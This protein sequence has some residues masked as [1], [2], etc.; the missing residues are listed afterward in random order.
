MTGLV[1]GLFSY[2]LLQLNH[3]LANSY[4]AI[5]VDGFIICSL[6]LVAVMY[7]KNNHLLSR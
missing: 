7:M 3:W 1:G 6:L 5:V 4:L 2:C